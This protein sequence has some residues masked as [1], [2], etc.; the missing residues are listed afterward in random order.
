MDMTYIAMQVVGLL[1]PMHPFALFSSI[2]SM[3][4]IVAS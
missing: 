4:F 1:V 3:V 2:S